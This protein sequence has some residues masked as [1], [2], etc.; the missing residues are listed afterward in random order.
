MMSVSKL[1]GWTIDMG[2]TIELGHLAHARALSGRGPSLDFLSTLLYPGVTLA[3][4][5]PGEGPRISRWGDDL[6]EEQELYA[7]NDAYTTLLFMYK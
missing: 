1:Q 3:G 6:S 5:N 7:A 2:P 4:K